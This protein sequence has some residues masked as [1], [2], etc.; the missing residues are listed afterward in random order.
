MEEKWK[1]QGDRRRKDESR[2]FEP[3]ERNYEEWCN[4]SKEREED[5]DQRL[6]SPLLMRRMLAGVV[7]RLVRIWIG[8]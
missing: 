4:G 3:S 2:R 5:E 8:F 1:Y 6:K 7:D